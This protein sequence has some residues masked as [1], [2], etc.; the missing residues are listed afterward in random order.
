MPFP[1]KQD[2]L[3]I[4][5]SFQPL[6]VLNS[7]LHRAWQS[8]RQVVINWA[9]TPESYQHWRSI[10]VEIYYSGSEEGRQARYNPLF[11]TR[12]HG[13][14]PEL[15][16]H[17]TIVLRGMR[18]GFDEYSRDISLQA[19]VISSCGP[20]L[21][22]QTKHQHT[23]L[24]S[25]GQLNEPAYHYQM[26]QIWYRALVAANDSQ[27]EVFLSPL[28]GGG[29][30]IKTLSPAEQIKAT[31]CNVQALCDAMRL[32]NGNY[33]TIVLT[34]PAG[35]TNESIIRAAY[36]AVAEFGG[37][38]NINI[39]T[40]GGI[41][42]LAEAF[43]RQGHPVAIHNPSS[44]HGLG[45][46]KHDARKKALEEQLFT[47]SYDLYATDHAV[48]EKNFSTQ[49]QVVA[50]QPTV[51]Y[52]GANLPPQANPSGTP[53]NHGASNRWAHPAHHQS[54]PATRSVASPLKEF[55]LQCQQT[56]SPGWKQSLSLTNGGG[57]LLYGISKT[58]GQFYA[59][60]KQNR[61]II[62]Q[63]SLDSTKRRCW[64]AYLE[65]NGGAQR[66]WRIHHD[67][68]TTEFAAQRLIHPSSPSHSSGFAS[69]R[70]G[71]N[72]QQLTSQALRNIMTKYH[73]G[74][75]AKWKKHDTTAASQGEAAGRGRVVRSS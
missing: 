52:T 31:R 21:G 73:A 30:Y 68:I 61:K 44:L 56:Y 64:S 48:R 25:G 12:Q 69:P 10:G 2:A 49:Y 11:K 22:R 13:Q 53:T 41:V 59:S 18:F 3:A 26:H 39:A 54:T 19:T 27:T 1:T 45:G 72:R 34:I 29:D 47:Q 50:C 5:N 57:T 65:E 6:P 17:R 37:D 9:N 24:L 74:P 33:P 16:I 60:I 51:H 62:H 8:K 46:M 4:I 42:S 71:A 20:D 40:Q 32:F 28:I 23:Y 35:L 63:V 7:D 14:R 70:A 15:N 58:T 43:S 55:A 66:D 38:L 36:E 67:A 75:R